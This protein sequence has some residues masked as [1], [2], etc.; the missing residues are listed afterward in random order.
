M[1]DISSFIT[2][3]ERLRRFCFRQTS[4]SI[5]LMDV[6]KVL[7]DPRDDRVCLLAEWVQFVLSVDAERLINPDDSCDNLPSIIAFPTANAKRDVAT[8]LAAS[9]GAE[10]IIV[11]FRL[12]EVVWP[13]VA[14]HLACDMVRSIRIWDSTLR[15]HKRLCAIVTRDPDIDHLAIRCDGS[16]LLRRSSGETFDLAGP[17]WLEVYNEIASQRCVSR[18]TWRKNDFQTKG[19]A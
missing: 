14:P 2:E 16:R 1:I 11:D 13:L 3:R 17:S 7:N 18:D 8:I 5:V 12:S 4:A 15:K 6:G 10:P 19:N 9:K